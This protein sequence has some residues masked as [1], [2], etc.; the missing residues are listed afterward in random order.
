[1]RENGRRE[2]TRGEERIE[3]K[4]GEERVILPPAP[5]IYKSGLCL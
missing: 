5:R 4:R 2:E 1:M 3:E